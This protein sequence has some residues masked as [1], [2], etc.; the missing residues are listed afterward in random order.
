MPKRWYVRAYGLERSN[1]NI[2]KSFCVRN[3]WEIWE[4]ERKGK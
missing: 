2:A 3:C 4:E 1:K